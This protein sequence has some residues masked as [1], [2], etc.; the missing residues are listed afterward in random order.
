MNTRP[1]WFGSDG[2]GEQSQPSRPAWGP[3]VDSAL[4]PS[5]ATKKDEE[6][7]SKFFGE[8]PGLTGANSRVPLSFSKTLIPSVIVAL[9]FSFC[10]G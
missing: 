3:A 9:H 4:P 2:V 5:P 7:L 10:S 6:T 8:S 1:K